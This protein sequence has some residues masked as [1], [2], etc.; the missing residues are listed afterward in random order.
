M[1]HADCPWR[2]WLKGVSATKRDLF[3]NLANV[4]EQSSWLR[5]N[6]ICRCFDQRKCMEE[7]YWTHFC[8][9]SIRYVFFIDPCNIDFIN[10]KIK[11]IAVC[12]SKCPAT[13]L[14]TYNDLKS[15][16]L[17]NGEKWCTKMFLRKDGFAYGENYIYLSYLL[18]IYWIYVAFISWIIF[19]TW[20]FVQVW[21]INEAEHHSWVRPCNLI[22]VSPS[23]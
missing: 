4:T 5:N 18:E 19:C 15:F 1:G 20:L 10:R 11:S 21:D 12:V 8:F 7:Q 2:L 3:I 22:C 23:Y 16:A 9:S 13:E 17:N 14:K 6:W